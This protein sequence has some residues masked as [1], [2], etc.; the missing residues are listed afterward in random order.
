M[1]AD[2]ISTTKDK[3]TRAKEF[4]ATFEQ[5]NILFQTGGVGLD[6]SE[7]LIENVTEFPNVVHDDQMDSMLLSMC[8]PEEEVRTEVNIA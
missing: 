5:G 3:V 4:Q 2:P 1:A 6:G 8:E 7:G